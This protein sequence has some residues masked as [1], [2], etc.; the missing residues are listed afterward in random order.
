MIKKIND[1]KFSII[2]LS[3]GILIFGWQCFCSGFDLLPGDNIDSR[4]INYILEHFR[5]WMLQVEPHKS[6]WD[7]PCLYPAKNTLAYSDVLLGIG[8]I[9]VPIRFFANEF[10]SFLI[11]VFSLCFLNF[12][13]FYFLLKKCFNYKYL[14][15]AVGA[16]FFAFSIIRYGHMIHVQ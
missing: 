8:V 7:M 6:F 2:F 3:F 4:F 14:A 5:L 15:S 13:T 12:S 10:H 16:F 1:I 9:Y 11:T